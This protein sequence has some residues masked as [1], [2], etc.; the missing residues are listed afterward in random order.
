MD[1]LIYF[2]WNIEVK[3]DSDAFGPLRQFVQHLGDNKLDGAV[4]GT[5]RNIL[6]VLNVSNHTPPDILKAVSGIQDS[7]EVNNDKGLAAIVLGLSQGKA[8][9]SQARLFANESSKKLEFLAGLASTCESMST[10]AVPTEMCYDWGEYKDMLHKGI[11]EFVAATAASKG[12]SESSA[13]SFLLT[14][15]KGISDFGQLICKSYCLHTLSHWVETMSQKWEGIELVEGP[16]SCLV[17]GQKYNLLTPLCH[18]LTQITIDYHKVLLKVYRSWRAFKEG[19]LETSTA[20]DA[21]SSFEEFSSFGMK[22]L[23]PLGLANEKGLDSLDILKKNMVGLCDARVNLQ[24]KQH[25]TSMANLLCKAG[26]Q[27]NIT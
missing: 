26:V 8:L 25:M 3:L 13:K 7:A 4:G 21:V 19:S 12:S 24:S 6:V 9:L 1:S 11:D 17:D 20:V 10:K 18:D 2:F 16:P 27:F 22:R 5:I 23:V 15:K 14:S